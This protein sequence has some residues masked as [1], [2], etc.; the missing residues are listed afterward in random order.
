MA[1]KTKHFDYRGMR[2]FP[3]YANRKNLREAGESLK[4]YIDDAISFVEQD[5]LRKTDE[6]EDFLCTLAMLCHP[7]EDDPYFLP[8]WDVLD[9][10][11]R[12]LIRKAQLYE[13]WEHGDIKSKTDFWIGNYEQ[14][15]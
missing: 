10:L 5:L 13:A 12:I 2:L 7:Y 6:W 4:K 3:V 9:E 1:A 11:F 8:N 14:D 15:K